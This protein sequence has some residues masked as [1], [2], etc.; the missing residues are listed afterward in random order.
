MSVLNKNNMQIDYT[1][2]GDG[3]PVILIHCSVFGNRQW[4]RL[5][6]KLKDRYRVLAVNLFGYGHTTPWKSDSPQTLADQARLVLE[7]CEVTGTPVRLV[8]HSLGGSVALKSA[9]LLGDK[10]VGLVLLE[11]NPFYLLAQGERWEAYEEIRAIVDHAKKYG[12][13]GDWEKVAER[14]VDYWTG[15]GTWR[16][17]SSKRRNVFLETQPNVFHEWDAVM[18]EI[19]PVETWKKLPAKTLLVYTAET[20]PL[21]REIAEIFKNACSNW[22][23]KEVAAGGHMAPLTHP[24]LINPIVSAFLDGIKNKS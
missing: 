12:K 7:L 14:F 18:N 5:S 15:D 21:L 11:P 17:M 10:C 1:D 9:Y 19:T 2:D 13:V 16:M 4:N 23:F 20:R 22:S 6:K 8:G 3:E 24:D